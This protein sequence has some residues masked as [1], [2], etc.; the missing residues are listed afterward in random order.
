M[1]ESPKCYYVEASTKVPK[2]LVL[3]LIQGSPLV[4]RL[5]II[6][7]ETELMLVAPTAPVS[8]PYADNKI[9]YLAKETLAIPPLALSEYCPLMAR[10]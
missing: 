6:P 8:V 5:E 2:L 4:S 3:V 7:M 1:V 10:N 9:E